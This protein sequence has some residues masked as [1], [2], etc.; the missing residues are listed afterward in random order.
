MYDILDVLWSVP[1]LV[2]CAVQ[3]LETL[4]KSISGTTN[5]PRG[6]IDRSVE[7][8]QEIGS[9]I[10]EKE[11]GPT[12]I[13]SQATMTDLSTSAST[14]CIM[15]VTATHKSVFCTVTA[16][17]GQDHP[18]TGE[19]STIA[20]N[21][22]EDC[23]IVPSLTSTIV[24][25]ASISQG[26]LPSEACSISNCGTSCGLVSRDVLYKRRKLRAIQPR[27]CKWAE[28]S[29]YS[30][31]QDFMAGEVAIAV[32]NKAS[33]ILD[34]GVISSVVGFMDQPISLAVEGLYGCTAVI[35][36]SRRGAW[37]AH[38]FEA[39]LF[40]PW[41]EV[42]DMK[43]DE[44]KPVIDAATNQPAKRMLYLNPANNSYQEQLPVAE[45]LEMF[46]ETVL[47]ALRES[48]G[49]S[50]NHRMGLKECRNSFIEPQYDWEGHM[51]DD[52]S[53]TRIFLLAP[54]ERT[55]QNDPNY[56][57]EFPSGLKL[58]WD[59][60]R[61]PFWDFLRADKAGPSFN[62]QI[63]SEILSYFGGNVPIETIPYAPRQGSG[64]EDENVDSNRGKVLVQYE[65]AVTSN[66]LSQAKWRIWFEGHVDT[67]R[68]ASWDPLPARGNIYEG[69]ANAQS[70]FDGCARPVRGPQARADEA[71]CSLDAETSISSKTDPTQSLATTSTAARTPSPTELTFPLPTESAR[72]TPVSQ[73]SDITCWSEADFPGHADISPTTQQLFANEFCETDRDRKTRLYSNRLMDYM[74]SKRRISSSG[75]NYDY[76]VEWK[77]GC[78]SN[79]PSQSVQYPAD[80][81]G[82]LGITCREALHGN[83][84]NCNNGGV[85]GEVQVGCLVYTFIGGK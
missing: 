61:N 19:C 62:E 54:L 40:R 42:E 14:S 15:S 16:M 71:A 66:D 5:L 48:D 52:G 18:L 1:Q 23:T 56:N 12:Q 79:Q 31:A 26:V 25:T 13:S 45:Q 22:I 38:I 83:F 10:I 57:N 76:K 69:G 65:P 51:F 2:S 44:G 72:I 64:R 75:I 3:I 77:S 29:N 28:H 30:P 78:Q 41:A 59:S 50:Q 33:V 43:D 21:T 37:A 63:R 34:G 17:V 70:C 85:G 7:L 55:P 84:K 60:D 80:P 74:Y 73:V 9:K 4:V 20:Y 32:D 8:L 46:K 39:P 53:D 68:T 82:A 6:D 35:A 49:A 58:M 24:S 27:V 67:V 47:G 36:V 11:E 81:N